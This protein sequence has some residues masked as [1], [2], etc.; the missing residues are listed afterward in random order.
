MIDILN[1][2]P[3]FQKISTQELKGIQAYKISKMLSI[4]QKQIN[5]YNDARDKL[6]KEC[7]IKNDDGLMQVD[8][9]GQVTLQQDKIKYFNQE[10]DK[11]LHVDIELNIPLLQI[12]DLE[13]FILTPEDINKIQWWI[14]E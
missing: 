7:C 4:I 8:Q 1:S 6:L 9:N 11:V 10:I 13:Q 12:S 2:S 5:L 14:E 3:V